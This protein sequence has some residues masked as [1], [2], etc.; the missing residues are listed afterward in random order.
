[1]V[2]KLLCPP[3][4]LI[5]EVA[6]IPTSQYTPGGPGLG[7]AEGPSFPPGPT[8]I[9]SK[10]A[11]VG[12]HPIGGL[13]NIKGVFV[14]AAPFQYKV[15]FATNP[16]GPWTPIKTA[17][18]DYRFNPG[19]PPPPIFL[20]YTP[21]VPDVN[22][23]YN[24]ADMGLDGPDY[25]T[26][27]HT[28]AAVNDQYYLKLTVRNAALTEF[29]S[30]VVPVRVDNTAPTKPVIKLQLQTPDG[31]RRDLG[32]C[33]TVEQGKGNLVIISL[34]ASDANFSQISVNLL[35]GCGAS[36][37]I[38]DTGGNSLSKTYKGDITDTGYPVLT[39]FAWDP[40]AAGI[41]PCCYLIDVRI[42]D[43]AVVSNFWSGGHGNENWQSI[44]IA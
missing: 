44:T 28:P 27:W 35:G 41:S 31:K 10:P 9:D 5:T 13:A 20:Y 39:E 18:D 24:V 26:D 16:A 8:P 22:G 21:R 14:I 34:Q 37:S 17:V 29:E 23:W 25:L 4:P 2:C 33:E 36:F 1:M 43:R 32:C 30:P 40:W 3:P 11:G 7:L 6:L 15:E 12:D 42:S 38:V 19:F